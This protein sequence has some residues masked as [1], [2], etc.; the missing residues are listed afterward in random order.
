MRGMGRVERAA[1]QADAHASGM[2]RDFAGS[3]LREG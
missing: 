2:K 1:E 3:R